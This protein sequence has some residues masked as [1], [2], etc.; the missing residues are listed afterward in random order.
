MFPDKNPD[1]DLALIIT[2]DYKNHEHI[3][4]YVNTNTYN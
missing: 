3:I 1:P 2:F 4:T